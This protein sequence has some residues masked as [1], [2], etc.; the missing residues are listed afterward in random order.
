MWTVL[1]VGKYV[2]LYFF[3]MLFFTVAIIAFT[4]FLGEKDG[5][6]EYMLSVYMASL[7]TFFMSIPIIIAFIQFSSSRFLY[8]TPQSR[9]II[10]KGIPISG[11][12][13]YGEI[14]IVSVVLTAISLAV[15]LTDGNRMSDM[16]LIMTFH[17]FLYMIVLPLP[18][19][20]GIGIIG[21]LLG[22]NS[23][24]MSLISELIKNSSV[25]YNIMLHGFGVPL[26]ISVFVCICVFAL[27]LLISL[28]ISKK[29]YKTRNAKNMVNVMLK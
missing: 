13:L 19:G 24:F 12:L 11:A 16:L 18:R 17:T 14:I 1:S 10:T 27:G 2:K 29:S 25:G 22:L 15:G 8:S 3:I 7:A 26:W 6:E 9:D 4:A 23:I 20:M 21:I 5:N 28:L